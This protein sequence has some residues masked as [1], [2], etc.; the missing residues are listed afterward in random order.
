M[1][2]ASS[3]P[4]TLLPLLAIVAGVACVQGACSLRSLDYL[5]NGH[6]QGGAKAD[7]WE[8]QEAAQFD[9]GATLPTDGGDVALIGQDGQDSSGTNMVTDTNTNTS[10][11]A[12]AGADQD[13]QDSSGARLTRMRIL[14]PG[15]GSSPTAPTA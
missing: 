6:G 10:R 4:R 12:S 7:A 9:A 14:T 3:A 13:G 11:D 2:S 5:G 15:R 1:T 8:A